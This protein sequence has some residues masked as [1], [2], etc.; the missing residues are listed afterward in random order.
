MFACQS[1]CCTDASVR[2]RDANVSGLCQEQWWGRCA[3]PGIQARVAR[4]QT[5]E[6]CAHAACLRAGRNLT[7]FGSRSQILS[8]LV[9]CPDHSIAMPPEETHIIMRMAVLHGHDDALQAGC[10]DVSQDPLCT[11]SP[12]HPRPLTL[13]LTNRPRHVC[14]HGCTATLN[15]ASSPQ[16][17]E[18][19]IVSVDRGLA[20]VNGCLIIRQH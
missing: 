14:T 8:N 16:R 10:W 7:G 2:Q 15:M 6:A 12:L 4:M 17:A 1:S 20:L 13:T 9:G 18:V 19:G 11:K 3:M 5:T